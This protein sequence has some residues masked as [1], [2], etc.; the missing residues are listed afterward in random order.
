MCD[1]YFPQYES[2]LRSV[3]YSNPTFCSNALPIA[4]QEVNRY[5]TTNN[6][7]YP[8]NKLS[9]TPRANRDKS[10]R[11]YDVD[12]A[13]SHVTGMD[14]DRSKSA[15]TGRSGLTPVNRDKTESRVKP[16]T[17]SQGAG[18]TP[19]RPDLNVNHMGK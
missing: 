4:N 13:R 9:R 15:L 19:K 2:G 1:K 11:H 6:A 7:Y 5:Q 12:E 3:K 14:D 16:V 18:A 17:P 8:S 10:A